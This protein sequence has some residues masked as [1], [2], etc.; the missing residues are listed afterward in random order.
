MRIVMR[1]LEQK[2]DESI[3]LNTTINLEKNKLID[4]I[5]TIQHDKK[6]EQNQYFTEYFL[7]I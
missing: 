6:K 7:Y 1:N 4:Q 2:L 3:K 5:S